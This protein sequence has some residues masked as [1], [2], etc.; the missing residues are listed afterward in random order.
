M[1]RLSTLPSWTWPGQEGK[2]LTVEVYSATEGVRL[3][4]ND[5]LIGEKP[6][7]RDQAFKAD[8]EV[9]YAPGTLKV[10]GIRGGKVVA[11][12][13][14]ETTGVPVRLKT[15]VDRT[16]LSADGEDLAFITVEAM[17]EKGRLQMNAEQKVHFSVSGAGTIAAVGNGDGQSLDPYSG[18]KCSLFHGRALV[19]L[20][21]SRNPGQIKL[22][23]NADGLSASSIAVESKK[24]KPLPELR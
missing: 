20:R 24:A 19:V 16:V 23:A 1:E 7:G 4:L 8:F 21:T 15:T 13:I 18:D 3:F 17:D 9:P 11:E 12:N 10:E 22:T 14:L 5:K 6:A 2:P